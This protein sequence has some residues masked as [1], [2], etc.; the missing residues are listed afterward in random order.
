M[1]YTRVWNSAYEASPAGGDQRNTVDDRIRDL[2]TDIRERMNTLVDDWQTDPVVA[3]SAI[4]GVQTGKE[5]LIPGV[6]FNPATLSPS[7]FTTGEIGIF[8][9][10]SPAQFV[11]Q[12]PLPAG[13]T[14]TGLAML[15]GIAGGGSTWGGTAG[16]SLIRTTYGTTYPVTGTVVAQITPATVTP[17]S[18]VIERTVA[19]PNEVTAA[20]RFYT[21]KVDLLRSQL[22]G[23]IFYGVKV[24][25]NVTTATGL[26]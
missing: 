1:A 5:W 2:K 8:S 25:Y 10:D 23:P 13:N 15:V 17:A 4:S 7:I 19:V 24:T 9:G 3:K 20:S 16:L 22:Y 18:S 11:A 12:L 26:R 6:A 14:I 21:L